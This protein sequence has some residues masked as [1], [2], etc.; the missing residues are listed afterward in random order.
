MVGSPE[1]E[2]Q[3]PRPPVTVPVGKIGGALARGNRALLV[4]CELPSGETP[5][6]RILNQ[7]HGSNLSKK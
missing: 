1:G 5:W 2:A 7:C 4:L 6:T 3:D